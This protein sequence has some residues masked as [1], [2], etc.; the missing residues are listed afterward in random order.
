MRARY[1]DVAQ[2]VFP[3]TRLPRS[4]SQKLSRWISSDAELRERLRKAGFRKGQRRL[5]AE[6]EKIIRDILGYLAA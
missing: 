1:I 3:E 6:Q 4:A 5:T 2:R